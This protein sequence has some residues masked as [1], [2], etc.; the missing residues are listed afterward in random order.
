MDNNPIGSL[1][2]AKRLKFKKQN[3]FQIYYGQKLDGSWL[4]GYLHPLKVKYD[5]QNAK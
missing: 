3:A 2:V 5:P 1:P 4:E